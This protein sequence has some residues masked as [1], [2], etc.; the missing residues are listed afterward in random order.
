[1]AGPSPYVIACWI[2]REAEC[3]EFKSLAVVVNEILRVHLAESSVE[4]IAEFSEQLLP[5]ILEELGNIRQAAL[6]DGVEPRY[7]LSDDISTAYLKTLEGPSSR[8]LSRMQAISPD[9]FEQ[10]C[11][12]I[13]A[14]LGAT[15]FKTGSTHDGGVDFLGYELQFGL[16]R[17]PAPINSRVVVIGQAKRYADGRLVT[18]SEVR[19]FVGGGILRVNELRRAMSSIGVLTPVVYAFW[20]SSEFNRPAKE[21]A[22]DMGIWYLNGLGLS[23]LAVRV[24]IRDEGDLMRILDQE[25]K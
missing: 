19:E 7:E 12:I 24:G 1:M 25:S 13:V 18:L 16:D 11:K 23:Q 17:G 5:K 20:T 3:P 14:R 9:G 2:A 6:L 8:I 10:F 15:S 4:E 22:R 21:Y